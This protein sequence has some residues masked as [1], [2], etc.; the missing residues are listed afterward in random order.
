M[1][2]LFQFLIV[3]CISA[4]SSLCIAAEYARFTVDIDGDKKPELIVMSISGSGD[5]QDFTV[6]IN[7]ATY[8]DKFFVV[9]G[10]LPELHIIATDYNRSSRQLLIKTSEPAWCNF[11]LLSYS[12]HKLYYLLKFKSDGD[13]ESPQPHGN[14]TLSV[15]HWEGFW[16][17]VETYRLDPTGTKL[18]L[19]PKDIYSVD[20]TAASK[21]D[22]ALEKDDC[23]RTNVKAG[24]FLRIE[25][26]DPRKLRFLLRTSDGVCGWLQKAELNN[27]VAEIPYAK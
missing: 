14:G 21:N 23:E 22:F 18:V 5:F 10:N 6:R 8:T 27:K 7:D 1:T 15:K 11:H 24:A 9:D 13:C 2:K 16:W 4:A 17:R 26:Y 12:N 25:K 20:I 3:L 19:I